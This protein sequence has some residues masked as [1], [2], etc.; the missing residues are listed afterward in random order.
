MT[1]A[2]G[3]IK[4][5]RPGAEKRDGATW[6]SGFELDNRRVLSVVTLSDHDQPR[7]TGII[8]RRVV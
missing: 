3:V 2:T 5:R 4:E 1:P 7:V 6:E 8:T